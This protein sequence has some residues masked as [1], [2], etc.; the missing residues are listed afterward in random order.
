MTTKP[1]IKI[2]PTDETRIRDAWRFTLDIAE[3]VGWHLDPEKRLLRAQRIQR[4]QEG[5]SMA[6]A[7]ASL[8]RSL[9]RCHGVHP[10]DLWGYRE[11]HI[12][13][14]E[15]GWYLSRHAHRRGHQKAWER[16]WMEAN[17]I[18]IW[19]DKKQGVV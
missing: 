3:K 18:A 15:L 9:A 14:I 6:L 10:G 13:M 8:L 1:D 5:V 2:G 17:S 16:L 11:G 19:L 12:P 7:R 4:S